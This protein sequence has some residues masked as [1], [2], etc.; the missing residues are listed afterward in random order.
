MGPE[1]EFDAAPQ[2]TQRWPR[3]AGSIRETVGGADRRGRWRRVKLEDMV[4]RQDLG[5]DFTCGARLS[6]DAGEE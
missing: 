1:S 2:R 5:A 3:G 4:E 6:G